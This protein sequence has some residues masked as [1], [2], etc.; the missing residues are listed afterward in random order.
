MKN[1]LNNLTCRVSFFSIWN[2]FWTTT[3]YYDFQNGKV[4]GY[5]QV[6]G[7]LILEPFSRG[8]LSDDFQKKKKE[9]SLPTTIARKYWRSRKSQKFNKLER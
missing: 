7:Y 3:P 1:K 4:N 2:Y 6:N 8:S 9:G 5:D